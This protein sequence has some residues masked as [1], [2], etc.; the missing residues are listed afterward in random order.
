M[1]GRPLRID[2]QEDEQTLYQLYKQ[3]KDHQNRTRLHALWLI[4]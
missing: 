4:R 1:N 2:W 3:E